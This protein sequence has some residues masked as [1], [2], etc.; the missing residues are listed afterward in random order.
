MTGS[1][2]I[3]VIA[4]HGISTE[5]EPNWW[6]PWEDVVR[7]SIRCQQGY[8]RD[9]KFDPQPVFVRAVDWETTSNHVQRRP[10]WVSDLIG[11]I[12]AIYSP[13]VNLLVS[14]AIARVHERG[15]RVWVL[16][17][18]LGSVLAYQACMQATAQKIKVERLITFG[19]PIWHLEY[20]GLIPVVGLPRS[21][22]RW[23][24]VLGRWDPVCGPF[25]RR[26]LGLAS[27]EVATKNWT[28]NCGHDANRYMRS[29]AMARALLL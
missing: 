12:A 7:E 26:W 3:S 9:G 18:S 10:G 2:P 19:S 24:N 8:V 21:V 23:H 4:I 20:F 5:L 27:I 15:D 13:Q 11:D 14:S 6:M 29:S 25:W 17:H 16:G 1:R 28:A 22:A